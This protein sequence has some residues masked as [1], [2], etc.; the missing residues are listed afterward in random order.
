MEL[1]EKE[2]CSMDIIFLWNE[3]ISKKYNDGISLSGKYNVTFDKSEGKI[4]KEKNTSYK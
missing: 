2:G 1:F 3:E 4:S